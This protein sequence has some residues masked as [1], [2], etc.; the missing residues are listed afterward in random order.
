MIKHAPL[1]LL[2][3]KK[4]FT[5]GD[6]TI[7]VLKGVSGQVNQ[8]EIVALVGQSGSGKST[9][10]QLA[11]LVDAPSSGQVLIN[12]NDSG[13]LSENECTRLRG[14]TIGFV[15]Q[16]HLLMPEFTALENV[17]LPQ[18]IVGASRSNAEKRAKE[19]LDLVGLSH[20]FHHIPSHLSGGEQQRVAIARSFANN[21]AILLAD[22]PT[23][24]LDEETA[25][26]VF[27]ILLDLVRHHNLAALIATHNRDL[28]KRMDRTWSLCNGVITVKR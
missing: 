24:S 10:L 17:I 28:A 15:Y 9:L 16:S 2:N 21:P 4:H 22:E 5:Q 25:G 13:T 20:R 18:L 3:L 11:G 1:S 12:G 23:G 14:K 19:L 6:V 26:R 27:Q 7:D 8:G